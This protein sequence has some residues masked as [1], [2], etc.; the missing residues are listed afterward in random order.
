MIHAFDYGLLGDDIHSIN[1]QEGLSARTIAL[2]CPQHCQNAH[3]YTGIHLNFR[4]RPPRTPPTPSANW[5]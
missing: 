5:G 1:S 4:R 2:H 3:N